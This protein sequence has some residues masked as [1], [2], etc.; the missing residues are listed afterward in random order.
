MQY[1]IM[2][3]EWNNTYGRKIDGFINEIIEIGAVKLDEEL[4]IV[5]EFS[6][7]VKS[8]IGR[9]LRGSVKRLTNI[10]NEDISSGVPFTK[11]LADFRKWVGM[12]Q[13]VVLTWGDGDIRVL[14]DNYRYLNGIERIP[15]LSNYADLQIYF[16]TVCGISLSRQAGLG[17][18]AR[19]L[20]I[21]EED[22]DSH[23]ALG[24]S[25]LSAECFRR[26]FDLP[27]LN[28]LMKVCDDSFYERLAFKACIINNINNPLIDRAVLNYDCEFCGKAA[29][30][31]GEWKFSGQYFRAVYV[32]PDCGKRFKV[33]VRFK[34]LYDSLEIKK[35]A[36]VIEPQQQEQDGVHADPA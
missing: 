26:I 24:D 28:A 13:N 1:I 20:G 27:K 31:T 11:A 30:L 36:R 16:H 32:C 3:L 29:T 12:E 5:G 34:K 33:G 9:K 18:A 15:F 4:N 19:L 35:S 8:Q 10:T 6:C 25:L 22:Y 23:R 17:A 21:N 14:I 7:F 2:D